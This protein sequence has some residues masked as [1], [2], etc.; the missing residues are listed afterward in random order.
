MN[1]EPQL[2]GRKVWEE[3]SN[4]VAELRGFI[5]AAL[6]SA[7]RLIGSRWL[8]LSVFALLGALIALGIW[9]LKPPVYEAD[10]TVS[11]QLYEKKIYADMI[12]KLNELIKQNNHVSLA[13]L[14]NWDLSSAQKV[15]HLKTYNIKREPLQHDLSTER[16]PFYISAGVSDPAVFEPLQ[17]ALVNYL[18]GTPYITERL[19]F[20]EKQHEER[21]RFLSERIQMNDSVSRFILSGIQLSGHEASASALVELQRE[22]L[23]LQKLLAETK[24]SIRFN[25]NIEVLDS[26]VATNGKPGRSLQGFLLYGALIGLGVRFLVLLLTGR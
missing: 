16:I 4:Q 19:S 2:R 13:E 21:Y 9:K 6:S 20:M 5:R 26:F 8:S 14:L 23:E 10:M 11:Y 24:G 3:V 17:S 1:E 7:G 22:N 25:V 18:N 15:I 12:A